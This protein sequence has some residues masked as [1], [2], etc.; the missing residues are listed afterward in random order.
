[1]PAFSSRT[2]G[3]LALW[4]LLIGLG[5]AM[6]QGARYVTDMS[7]FLPQNPDRHQRLL[8][9]QIKDG[10]LSRLLLIGL[11]GGSAAER[12]D[13]SRALAERLRADP[14][15]S[16]VVNGDEAS[17]ARDHTLLMQQR[18]ALSPRVDSERFTPAGLHAALQ[19]SVT[20]LSGSAGMLLRGVFARDP[21]GELLAQLDRV[22]AGHT[23]AS[24]EGVWATP[25]GDMALMMALSAAPG[26]DTD[27]QERLLHTL[28]EAFTHARASDAVALRVSGAPVF[29]VEARRTIR[30]E[31]K[32]LS[33]LGG[34]TVFAL[35]L[36]F[37]RS[38]R[39]VAIGLVPVA[40][41]IVAAIAAVALG[42]DAVHAVTI[43]FGTTLMGETIDYSIYYLVQADDKGRSGDWRRQC[44]PTIRLGMLTSVCGFAALTF[45]SFP[46]LAQLGVYSVAGLL[47]AAAVTRYVLPVLP[48]APVPPGN[49]RWVGLRMA[50]LHRLAQRLRWPALGLAV[51]A[52]LLV[53]GQRHALWAE[54]LAGL[55]PA[56]LSLQ[57]LDARLRHEA[58]APDMRHLVVVSALSADEAL[59]AAERA[60]VL[61]APWLTKGVIARIDSPAHFLPSAAT[62]AARRAA[63]PAPDELRQRLR[64][65]TSGL[66]VA[67]ERLEPFIADVAEARQAPPLTP[68]T[69][70][71]SSFG[72]ALQTLLLPR[73]GGHAALLP[74]HLAGDVDLA[75]LHKEIGQALAASDLPDALFVD[76][77][78]QTAEMFGTY[79]SEALVFT[80]LGALA[81]V[82]VLGVALRSPGRL[83][84]V[85]LPL[86]G[87]V[88][89]VMAAHL[90]AGTRLTLLHL[91]GLLLI[92]A[93]GS[94]YALFFEQNFSRPGP[95]MTPA[96]TTALASLALANLSTMIGFGVLGLSEVPVLHAMGTTVGPGALLALLLA[97]A[98]SPRAPL[99]G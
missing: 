58:G 38:L 30:N 27:A 96:Q 67:P 89:L 57:A 80:G 18:Y 41:G 44:W 83:A 69:L 70:R 39:N 28:A 72:F 99:R 35:M 36:V 10:A 78:T 14:A 32:R 24:R 86:A 3:V 76:L 8:V 42:F 71:G 1:M 5:V 2:A 50:A 29:S 62:Q 65:A 91:I 43:G 7:A 95:A 49:I 98:W 59:A 81:I 61:L 64:Q 55:N 77:D 75:R 84:R 52:L 25:T 94:N 82:G 11:E 66:P 6:V 33:L 16:A 4:L 26:T 23:P 47:T 17:Q 9:D 48:R 87:A 54:G 40:S 68:E 19:D 85:L 92:V 63:L 93:V 15:F 45:S 12:A 90:L 31:V 37:Y 97:M 21:T 73:A 74:V 51:A 60:E 22:S 53:A 88:V 13:T 20:A 46:G 56:P 79:L 34:L